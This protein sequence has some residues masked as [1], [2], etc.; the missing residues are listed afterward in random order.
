MVRS[1]VK[2]HPNIVPVYDFGEDDD[3]AYVV[4]EA[5]EGR[6]LKACLDGGERFDLGQTV[7]IVRDACAALAFAHGAGVIHGDVH[8]G[9]LIL[10]VSNRAKLGGFGIPQAP[11]KTRHPP[12]RRPNRSLA[13]RSTNAREAVHGRGRL[14]HCKENHSGRSASAI[15]TQR[16]CLVAFR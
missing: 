11:G 9:N 10:D 3:I 15:L 6:L 16:R 2:S 8:A 14:G 5:I 13:A 7:R 4:T 1:L 12:Q